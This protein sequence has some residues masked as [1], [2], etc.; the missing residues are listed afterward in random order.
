MFYFIIFFLGGGVWTLQP[1]WG[2]GLFIVE[3]CGSRTVKYIRTHTAVRTPLNERTNGSSQRQL[4]TQQTTNTQEE[5][6]C[7]Q[8]DSNPRFFWLQTYAL[9]RMATEISNC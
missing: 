8:R 1:K 4:P 2:V 6:P 3:V 9:E 7:L 5:N